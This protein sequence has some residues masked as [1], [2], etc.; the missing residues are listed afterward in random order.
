MSE[1]SRR[2]ILPAVREES[3]KA[4]K[5]TRKQLKLARRLLTRVEQDEDCSERKKQL[6]EA[7]P[8]LARVSAFSDE[9]RRL[10][11][12]HRGSLE[13]ARVRLVDW[14]GRAEESGI[15]T[16]EEFAKEIRQLT[17]PKPVGS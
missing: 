5:F 3:R 14:V 16:L 11:A 7:I 2:V 15:Q 13:D 1:F 10:L 17:L 6:L 12:S 8:A 9:L 4:D